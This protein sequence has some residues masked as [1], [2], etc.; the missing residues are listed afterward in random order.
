MQNRRGLVGY[1]FIDDARSDTIFSKAM[2]L[3]R[4]GGFSV[5][6]F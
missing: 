3:K 2:E 6:R 4:V 1:D 5:S